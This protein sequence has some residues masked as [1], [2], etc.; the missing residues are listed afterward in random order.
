MKSITEKIQVST[1]GNSDMIDLSPQL[2]SL[3][4]SSGITSGTITAFVPGSTAGITTIE[5][6]PGLIHDFKESFKRVAPSTLRYKHNEL[7]GDDNGH[8]HVCAA[9]LGPS[10]VIPIVNGR[11]TLGTWQQAILMDFDT[12]PRNREVI[13]QLIGL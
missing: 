4:K 10:V 3:L 7:N 11:M 1:K 8:A 5:Y 2:S 6:E 13:V 12:R 9:M